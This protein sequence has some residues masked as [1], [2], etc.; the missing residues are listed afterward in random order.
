MTNPQYTGW[1]FWL[2][3]KQVQELH[4]EAEGLRHKLLK[5][6]AKLELLQA[7]HDKAKKGTAVLLGFVR[8]AHR[9]NSPIVPGS[10]REVLSRAQ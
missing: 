1:R 2:C 5:T 9:L 7:D 10:A 8:E 6:E 3:R 4:N